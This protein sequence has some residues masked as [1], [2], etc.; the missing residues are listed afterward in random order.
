MEQGEWLVVLFFFRVFL[1]G[2]SSAQHNGSFVPFLLLP[3]FNPSNLLLFLPG[4]FIVQ[5]NKTKWEKLSF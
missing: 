1:S 3:T 2:D 4:F 5:E